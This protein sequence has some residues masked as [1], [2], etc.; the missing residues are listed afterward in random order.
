VV[1]ARRDG[2]TGRR[3]RQLGAAGVDVAYREGNLRLSPHLFTTA[4]DIDRAVEELNRPT[5]PVAS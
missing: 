1:L 5:S 3:Y 2:S 4:G